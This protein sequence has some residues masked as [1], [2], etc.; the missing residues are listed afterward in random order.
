MAPTN[1][2]ICFQHD[3][4]MAERCLRHAVALLAPAG[5][6]QHNTVLPS[7]REGDTCRLFATCEPCLITRGMKS[8]LP[9]VYSEKI[10]AIRKDLYKV[11]G[12][13]LMQPGDVPVTFADTTPLE[14]DF[15][16]RPSTPL[17][18]GLRAF[19]QWYAKYYD[20]KQ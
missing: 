20:T 15:G 1:W 11:F 13:V 18:Q 6:T 7:A 14:R 17:R 19:A 9:R 2:A 5:L 16:F 8:T 4:P 12:S 10:T 3:C